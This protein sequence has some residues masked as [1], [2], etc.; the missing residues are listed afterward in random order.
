MGRRRKDAREFEQEAMSLKD[1]AK[2]MGVHE[3]NARKHA[4]VIPNGEPVGA[5][6]PGRFPLPADRLGEA[7]AS[8]R[9]ARFG[10]GRYR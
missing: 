6:P 1:F 5:L 3:D 2:V 8:V 4:I 7:G 9:G 10:R